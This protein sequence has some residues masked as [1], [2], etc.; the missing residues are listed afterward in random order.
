MAHEEI[1]LTHSREAGEAMTDKQH[2]IVQMDANG[3]IEVG[4]G[5]TDLLVGVLQNTPDAGQQA[6]YAYGGIAKVKLGGTVSAAGAW[7]TSDSAGKG[8]ATTTDGNRVIGMALAAGV[9]G[10]II[11]VQ[12][13]LGWFHNG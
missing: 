3:E 4:E 12:L 10:D 11:P 6:V 9:D 5:A 2:Y 8:V 1:A 7:I 13:H